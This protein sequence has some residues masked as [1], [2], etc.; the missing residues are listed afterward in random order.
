[1]KMLLDTHPD[2][3]SQWHSSKNLP[4]QLS[5]ISYGSKRKVWWVGSCGHEWEA[6]VLN[7]TQHK[8]NCPYCAGKKVLT[9]FNDLETLYP[10]IAK[11]WSKNNKTLANQVRPFSHTKAWWVGACG[12]EWEM[13]VS[14]K[15]SGQGCPHCK[16]K[17]ITPGINDL[18]TKHPTIAK[19]WD[20][21]KN[22]PLSASHIAPSAKNKH[23][24]KCELGHEWEA[25]VYSRTGKN[26]NGCPYC[27]FLSS[28]SKTEKE[29]Y[30]NLHATY[31]N[32]IIEVNNRTLLEG[33]EIDIYLPEHSLAIEYNGLYWHSENAGKN[34]TYHYN[35]WL[36]CEENNIQLFYIWED[37]YK[38]DK[39]KIF[40]YL[41]NIIQQQLPQISNNL[42]PFARNGSYEEI[43]FKNNNWKPVTQIAPVVFKTLKHKNGEHKI[44]DAGSTIWVKP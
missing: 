18:A 6:T 28:R 42:L 35:K 1:M 23:Y 2:I 39:N 3:A 38:K 11:M 22:F 25:T 27:N 30:E 37:E 29:I 40:S 32:K 4:L 5:T 17:I 13:S 16:N 7:R 19:E 43:V 12:H 15:V 24:W 31:P 14:K 10:N 36:K 9:N 33:Q 26:K 41:H 8:Q 21:T 34:S 20:G 44:W